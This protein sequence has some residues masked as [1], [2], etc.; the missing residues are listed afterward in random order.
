MSIFR[1]LLLTS[2]AVAF[3]SCFAYSNNV[4]SQEDLPTQAELAKK[5][6]KRFD[7]F[8]GN[9]LEELNRRYKNRQ[10]SLVPAESDEMKEL[11]CRISRVSAVQ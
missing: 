10:Q 4:S 6:G 3:V 2:A 8:N 11:R 7:D 1:K 9:N 5:C